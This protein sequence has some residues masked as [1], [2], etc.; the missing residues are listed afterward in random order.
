MGNNVFANGMEVSCKAA[1][2]K[3]IAAFPDICFTPPQTPA[4]PPGV[5]IPYPNTAF[6][7]DTTKGSK[8]VKISKKEV[9][10]RNKSYFKT[11]TG[12]EAGCA[13]KKGI[14]TSKIKGKAYFIK[15]S[16][17]VKVEGQNVVR[18]LDM[19][20]HNHGSNPNTIPW[21]FVDTQA[22]APGGACHKD[23]QKEQEACKEYKP[24]GEK[25]VCPKEAGGVVISQIPKSEKQK[26]KYKPVYEALAEK[27]KEGC[28][29]ARKCQLVPYKKEPCTPGVDS[30]CPGQTGDHVMDDANFKGFA[31]YSKNDAPVVCASG[32]NQYWASHG[33]SH[34]IRGHFVKC[35]KKKNETDEIPYGV[36]RKLSSAAVRMT[37]RDS[38]CSKDC[39]EAQLDGYYKE[40]NIVDE[41]T[42]L[43]G[44]Q[45]GRTGKSRAK[46]LMKKK[47]KEAKR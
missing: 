15:W 13:P 46:S 16:M 23:A 17:D 14:M 1:D 27:G 26:K 35:Y 34:T 40:K 22:L 28:L 31:N 39:L 18:H 44:S 5:P 37:F 45:T 25:D 11:S 4:T 36:L 30:C 24:Y 10:L 12:D 41:S 29:A 20:T 21:P 33:E 2:G 6:A 43:K 9:M 42:K 32:P 19:T 38:G 8:T 3:S 7:K 47:V